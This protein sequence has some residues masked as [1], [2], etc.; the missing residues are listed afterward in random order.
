MFSRSLAASTGSTYKLYVANAPS[1]SDPAAWS[2]SSAI[3]VSGNA[4]AVDISGLVSGT[5]PK[6]LKIEVNA[7]SSDA[8]SRI[9]GYVQPILF[10]ESR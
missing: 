10:I 1:G 9:A 3:D 6:G 5:G 4:N 8:T 7:G 2:W